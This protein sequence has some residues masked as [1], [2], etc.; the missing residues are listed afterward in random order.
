MALSK[1]AG[2]DR[3][4]LTVPIWYQYAEGGE[5]W[6]LTGADSAKTRLIETAG[7]FS[8]IDRMEPTVGWTPFWTM[9]ALNSAA[10]SSSR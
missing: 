2:D 1:G 3:G 9:P 4:P 10:R 7:R 6:L 8:L 5:P